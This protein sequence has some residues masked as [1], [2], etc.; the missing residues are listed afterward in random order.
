[1]VVSNHTWE[2]ETRKTL[3]LIQAEL[4]DAENE[5]KDAQEKVSRLTREAETME[6]ALQIHLQRTGK[7]VTVEQ[8]FRN[9]LADQ[10]NHQERI[11]RIAE[12]NNG[13]L[14]VGV[15]ADILYNYQLLKSKARM[16]AYR[17]IY[18]LLINMTEAGVFQKSAPG[19]FRLVNFLPRLENSA[20]FF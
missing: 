19:E 1:M 14:K 5:Y 16:N 11:K 9:L 6:L 20:K 13:L 3:T 4:H 12:Q 7:Q 8:D 10:K 15:A 2:E 18:G 17:I